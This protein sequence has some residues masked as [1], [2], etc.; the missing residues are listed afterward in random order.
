MLEVVD[1]DLC[2]VEIL[3]FSLDPPTVVDGFKGCLQH[4]LQ[5]KNVVHR[6]L[7]LLVGLK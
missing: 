3:S 7:L 2:H 5:T 1:R 6:R 4:N